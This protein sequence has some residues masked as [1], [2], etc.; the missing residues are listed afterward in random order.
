MPLITEKVDLDTLV[1][2]TGEVQANPTQYTI[3]G[4]LKDIDLD[5]FHN[6]DA[7]NFG[8]N[9]QRPN[10]IIAYAQGD[11][12]NFS[13]TPGTLPAIPIPPAFQGKKLIINNITITINKAGTVALTPQI[14]FY[15][16]GTI[17]T[18]SVIGDNVP[19]NPTFA[20]EISYMSNILEDLTV[21]NRQVA[22]QTNFYTIFNRSLNI[23]IDTTLNDNTNI[24]FA[25]LVDNA[26]G[27]TPIANEQYNIKISGV[28]K[29]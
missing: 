18:N 11:I 20:N 4:R 7:F 24:F 21:F 5:V 9:L 13:T 27:Y 15:N 17:G 25:L 28:V 19:F 10:D 14:N 22:T 29:N 26:G 12:I 2:D 6:M 3:L 23:V 8:F 16:L 1:L